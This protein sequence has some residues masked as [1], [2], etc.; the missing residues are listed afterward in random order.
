MSNTKNY[1]RYPFTHTY[2]S[3]A[4]WA[5]KR[6]LRAWRE[7]GDGERCWRWTSLLDREH[8][9][10]EEVLQPRLAEL[11]RGLD[12]AMTWKLGLAYYANPNSARWR[13]ALAS[14]DF[15]RMRSEEELE[16][17]LREELK[18]LEKRFKL[19]LPRVALWSEVREALGVNDSPVDEEV[20]DLLEDIQ[21]ILYGAKP[22][23]AD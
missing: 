18:L 4:E 6:A 9:V 19:L 13:G 8:A 1:P 21:D 22:T 7:K 10:Y 12:R 14:D 5:L 11:R 16:A 17:L 20:T 23:K 2:C 15:K 3:P